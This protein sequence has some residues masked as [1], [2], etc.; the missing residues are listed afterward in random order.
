M[1]RPEQGA[2]AG[3]TVRCSAAR[4]GAGRLGFC[5]LEYIRYLTVTERICAHAI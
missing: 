5:L 4:D 2:L 1:P 3:V